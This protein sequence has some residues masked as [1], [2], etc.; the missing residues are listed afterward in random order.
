VAGL[1][2]VL[3]PSPARAGV[4]GR[5]S[6]QGIESQPTLLTTETTSICHDTD[7][8]L[9]YR[10]VTV[11]DMILTP[12]REHCR[13]TRCSPLRAV[14]PV[15]VVAVLFIMMTVFFRSH[16]SPAAA[17]LVAVDGTLIVG[18][19]AARVWARTRHRIGHHHPVGSRPR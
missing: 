9:R 4:A 3:Q 14:L 19:I 15:L 6:N 8:P 10:W 18:Y 17:V 12:T 11:V 7:E 5:T 16:G 2:V 1:V 13:N